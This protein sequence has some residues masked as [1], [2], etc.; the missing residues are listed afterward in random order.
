MHL[1]SYLLIQRRDSRAYAPRFQKPKDEGW[2]IVIGDVESSEVVAVKRVGYVRNRSHAQITLLTP[3][4]IGRVIYTLYLMS[5]CY[6][7][8]D[9]QYD[10]YVDIIPPAAAASMGNGDVTDDL[11][12]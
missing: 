1:S 11:E 2:I 4:K 9:Q 6:L 5:D 10:L 12:I 7:G 3:D 8:L